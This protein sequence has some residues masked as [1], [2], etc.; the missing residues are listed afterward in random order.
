M[1]L[2][3]VFHVNKAIRLGI[4]GVERMRIFRVH[5]S[6]AKMFHSVSRV[7]KK[8]FK[9]KMIHITRIPVFFTTEILSMLENINHTV[10]GKIL[11]GDKP[12]VNNFERMWGFPK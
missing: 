8:D 7:E 11:V 2:E 3:P 10:H 4:H 1:L 12:W 6:P 9:A 5:Q